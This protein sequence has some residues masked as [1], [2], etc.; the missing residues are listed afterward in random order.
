M[1]GSLKAV[2]VQHSETSTGIVNDIEA[3][4]RVVKGDRK[5]IYS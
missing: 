4:G 5:V 3:I 1:T 2:L